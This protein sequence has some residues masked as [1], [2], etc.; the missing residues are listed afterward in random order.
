MVYCVLLQWNFL[1]IQ[2]KNHNL[3]VLKLSD[4]LC[5][6]AIRWKSSRFPSELFKCHSKR[7][8]WPLSVTISHKTQCRVLDSKYESVE[9]K[10]K[11]EKID[12]IHLFE[13]NPSHWV[14]NFMLCRLSFCTQKLGC[15]SFFLIL[16]YPSICICWW[17]GQYWNNFTPF[18]SPSTFSKPI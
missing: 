3:S 11:L 15:F 9:G 4:S 6:E 8:I 16:R 10:T 1:F 13:I 12:M 17:G 7:Y 18:F 14:W 2:L 5:E